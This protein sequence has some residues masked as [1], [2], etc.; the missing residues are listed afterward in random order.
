MV[1][2]IILILCWPIA[3]ALAAGAVVFGLIYLGFWLFVFSL[4][5]ITAAVVL[6]HSALSA[7]LAWRDRRMMESRSFPGNY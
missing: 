2:L 7:F 1:W 6:G 3:L 4:K 5:A